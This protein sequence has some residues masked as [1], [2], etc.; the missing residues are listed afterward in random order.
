LKTFRT[1]VALI[2]AT[3]GLAFATATAADAHTHQAAF[4]KL[5][6]KKIRSG[7]PKSAAKFT[8]H[9]PDIRDGGAF[10]A[11]DFAN[12]FGCTGTNHQPRLAWSGA[13][14]GTRSYAV[15]MYDPDAPTGSGFWHWL[16]WDI[17]ASAS[18]LGSTPPAGAVAGVND[19]GI[20]GYVGPCPPVGDIA[21]H[22][23]ITVYALDVASLSL[24]SSTTPAITGFTMATHI[25]GF[26]R[27]TVT[28]Q[29]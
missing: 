28:A 26:A 14:A 16:E 27:M 18:T 4:I 29:R 20:T 21:H 1:V 8:V 24:P 6:H 15:T 11:A 25:L 7:I 23:Q 12:V 13:P 17:P 5:G 2:I 19:G 3:A 22:F 10:P 9:S